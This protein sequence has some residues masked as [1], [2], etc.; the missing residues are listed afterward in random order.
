VPLD[1]RQLHFITLENDERTPVLFLTLRALLA[2]IIV[3]V[4]FSYQSALFLS[5]FPANHLPWFYAF[6]AAVTVG[7]SIP[8]TR[9]IARFGEGRGDRLVCLLFIAGL[10]PGWFLDLAGNPPAAV[11][12]YSTWVKMVGLFINIFLWHHATQTFISRRAKVILPF[13]AAGFSLGSAIGG[14]I[15]QGLAATWG[16]QA[17][18]ALLMVLVGALLL[19]PIPP[20]QEVPKGRKG[21]GGSI[22]KRG[23]TTLRENR[24]A[25][26]LTVFVLLAIPVFLGM[27]FMLKKSLQE[28]WTRDAIAG[29]MGKYYFY[30]NL[31][32]FFL[33]TLLMGKLMRRV[34]VPRMTWFM[35]VFLLAALPVIIFAPLFLPIAIVA[36]TSATLKSTVYINARNQLITPLSPL[37]KESTSM[38]LR[39]VVTPIGTIVASFALIPVAGAG[40]PVIA[41]VNTGIC[42]VFLYSA[43][44][45]ASAYMHELQTALR[46]RTLT[47]ELSH[48][49][50]IAPDGR[51]VAHL[52]QRLLSDEPDEAIF[53]ATLLSEYNEL[54]LADLQALWHR[55][56]EDS[57]SVCAAKAVEL[58]RFTPAA[59]Q[60]A[61]FTRILENPFDA[62][63]AIRVLEAAIH[64]PMQLRTVLGAQT[65]LHSTGP[66]QTATACILLEVSAESLQKREFTDLLDELV[67]GS[68]HEK[69]LALR[70]AGR[71]NPAQ[72]EG[73]L[74]ACLSCGEP[75][76]VKDA[77]GRVGAQ[78]QENLYDACYTLSFRPEYR[79][80]VLDTFRSAG[81]ELAMSS[82]AFSEGCPAGLR[83]EWIRILCTGTDP[84]TA[85]R[86]MEL[87]RDA[88]A[89]TCS[90]VLDQLARPGSL[91]LPKASLVRTMQRIGRACAAASRAQRLTDS[92]LGMELEAQKRFWTRALFLCVRLMEPTH[93]GELLEIE[94]S[95]F[96]RD[97]RQQ[98]AG[99][100][101]W[102]TWFQ[103]R[104]KSAFALLL[105]PPELP[106][107]DWELEP[108]QDSP[109]DL[110]AVCCEPRLAKLLAERTGGAS[111]EAPAEDDALAPAL[112]L[113]QSDF[114]RYL[115]TE[116][117]LEMTRLGETV[118][119]PAGRVLFEEK[120]P[121]D[122]LYCVFSGRLLV[123]IQ[124][125]Q[126]N[127]L[128]QGAVFGEIALLDSGPRSAT[129]AAIEDSTLLKISRETFSEVLQEHP[130][131]VKQV[132]MTLAARIRDLVVLIER[133]AS[134]P[135]R[136]LGEELT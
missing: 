42:L 75:E 82:R 31:T 111:E 9:I 81:V 53:A 118:Q 121:G 120:S 33:Q 6:A 125:T 74:S 108:I 94:K 124:K 104:G 95:V 35:P 44:K 126:V 36:I 4:A 131:V 68:A 54:R 116:V 67:A 129:I 12:I 23:F 109:A 18:L 11:F 26:W 24:L 93:A 90:V 8:Y 37:E 77:I 132:A 110:L 101:L 48:N 65:Q 20:M 62:R 78:R 106:H 49:L 88:D 105:E 40:I 136:S 89:W 87:L 5:R 134:G 45:A 22:W 50:A 107:A 58:A 30:T 69:R 76:V 34:G 25:L 99:L 86:I 10:V 97:L 2:S 57:F 3:V 17:L 112:F 133:R 14:I 72:G 61:F 80:T 64:L 15:V 52:R 84:R 92:F 66:V 96:S 85:D 56:E 71:L 7:F 127:E 130:F 27:D 29:F 60:E 79:K 122:A 55:K 59:D 91:Q 123:R 102:E 38:L 21:G 39:T 51:V 43:H 103:S 115:P 1:L 70:L 19:V 128:A 73:V 16:N 98:N 46:K 135:F 13:I 47:P 114:F 28:R 41:A 100:E 119:L 113:R 117:L 63:M 83:K 32:V